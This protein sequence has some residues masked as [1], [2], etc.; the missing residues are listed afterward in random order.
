[1]SRRRHSGHQRNVDGLLAAAQWKHHEAQRKVDEAIRALLREGEPI[2]FRRVATVARVSTGWLYA[3]PDV[4]GR[5]MR[6]RVQP[7]HN[8]TPPGER[9]SDAS[10]DA[11]VRALRQRVTALDTERQQLLTR[12]DQLQQRIEMLYGELYTKQLQAPYAMADQ[13]SS[14]R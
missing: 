8:A 3:Q 7:V 13:T 5:I 2:N 4:K 9:A 1:M 10:R 6:L 11:I 14:T 12:I